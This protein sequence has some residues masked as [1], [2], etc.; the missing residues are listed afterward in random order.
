MANSELPVPDGLSLR[1]FHGVRFA[2]DDISSVT[3]PP[4]DLVSDDEARELLD[5]HPNNVVR[6]ILPGADHHRYAQARDTLQ[7]WLAEGV[8]APDPEPAVYVYEQSRNGDILQ[9]GLIGD[10]ALAAPASRII[11]PHEE[12]YP[13]PIADRL[14]LMKSTQANLEPIF[15]LYEGVEGAATRLT[16]EVAATRMPLLDTEIA[17]VR[18]RL[19]AITDTAE[20]ERIDADL[21]PRRALIADGHHRYATY[22]TLQREHHD[23]GDGPGPWDYGLAL[24]VDSTAYPPTSNPSTGS[25]P[26]CRWARRSPAPKV[27]GRCTSTPRSPTVSPPSPKRTGPPSCSPAQARAICS[28]IPTRCRS[29]MPCRKGGRRAGAR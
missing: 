1:P 2:V 7:T 3:S 14:A 18:H 5:A 24:L 22:R 12:V 9:R 28:P 26:A 20:I 10:V 11:L 15:L 17:G 4:Y 8:L 6:L 21:R 23:A 19:W 27:R 16:D 13:G 29:G 25:S